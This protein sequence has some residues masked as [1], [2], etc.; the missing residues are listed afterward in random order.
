MW[1]VIN[2]TPYATGSTWVQDKDANKIWLVV[3]KA[4]FD[5]RPDGSCQ[6]CDQ[7]IPVLQIAK[8]LGEFG[9]SS[10]IYEADLFGIKT[11]TDILVRG[12]A[13]S[14]RDEPATAVDVQLS[15]G[16][17]RKRLRVFG[18]RVW[19]RGAFGVAPSSPQPFESMPIVYERAYGGWDRA[20]QDAAEHRMESRNPIG[21]GFALS[22]DHCVGRPLPN[23]EWP[24]RLIDSWKDRP[25]PAG[26]NA[27]ECHWTPRRELAG[28]YDEAWLDNRFPLWAQDFNPRYNNCAP[29][30]QQ[31][32]GFL[33]GGE[34]VELLNLSADGQMRFQLPRIQPLFETRF[35]QESVEHRA[36]LC[37]VI[38]E[39]DAS[40]LIMAW[41]T[42]L[43][44]NQRMDDL[45]ATVVSQK[46]ML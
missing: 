46:R 1:L 2:R 36:Q 30:D 17:I 40:R 14:P 32:D 45:D 38:I 18:D 20:A 22:A 43:I 9:Q 31:A 15:L 37:S 28:T 34:S 39:P 6:L 23:I 5:I 16:A 13:W 25:P 41:Q 19:E 7:Q 12:S 33:R 29:A 10:L 27:V 26:L 35:K 24:D 4:T 3:L 44:C 21:V 42:S 8:P 11:C